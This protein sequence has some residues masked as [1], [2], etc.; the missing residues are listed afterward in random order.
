MTWRLLGLVLAFVGGLIVAYVLL[1]L[2]L[3]T[4]FGE[5]I[6]ITKC[7]GAQIERSA[8]KESPVWEGVQCAEEYLVEIT[9]HGKWVLRIRPDLTVERNTP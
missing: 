6:P 4:A 3:G 8:W 2:W 7:V 9:D 1:M 5:P